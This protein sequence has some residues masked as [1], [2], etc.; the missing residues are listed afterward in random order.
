MEKEVI[1]L[2]VSK[3]FERSFRLKSIEKVYNL[4]H[5]LKDSKGIDKIGL[6]KFE[7]KKGEHFKVIN[8]KCL[9]ST[10]NFSPYL[11]K[12]KVKG[13]NKHP[14]VISIATL[15]DKVVLSI[16]KET[17][18][19]AFPECINSKLPNSYIREI[20]SFI[21]PTTHDKVRFLKVDIEKFFDTIK[22]DEL[23]KALRKKIKSKKILYLIETA[24]QNPTVGIGYKREEREKLKNKIGVPQGLSISSILANIY[25]SEVDKKLSKSSFKYIRYVDDILLMSSALTHVQLLESVSKE[26]S[27]LGLN[28]NT[29]KIEKGYLNEEY[30]YLGY[31]FK[32]DIIT[33]R[34]S[35]INIFIQKI[36]AKFTWFN[37]KLKDPN[38]QP[39]LIKDNSYLK[40]RFVDIINEKITGAIDEKK[41]YGWIFYFL[42]INDLRLLY[43]LDEI[44]KGFFRRQAA[45]N[46]ES[47]IELKSFVKSYYHARH[48]PTTGY[49]HNYNSYD[50]EIKKEN[51]L[52][53]YGLLN[54][55][56]SYSET[57]I[58]I[59]FNKLK[60][61][62]IYELDLDLGE[63]Y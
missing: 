36:A 8:K 42:E 30:E 50:T 16:L 29:D 7:Q 57:E 44:I 49:I 52:R 12:L 59:A 62:N 58:N 40:N 18:H 1:A 23:L 43:H 19:H 55:S 10:Y 54:P 47:P 34:Q 26:L 46:F 41:R 6:A 45:F 27:V 35:T 28:L 61:E 17:L 39:W 3:F 5:A 53:R 63:L 24:I 22:H 11:E 13:K 15:R 51:L 2:P 37:Y 25:I 38:L 9:N 4:K 20:N 60:F 32:N 48:Y 31:K 33:I 21:F 56:L 14:R